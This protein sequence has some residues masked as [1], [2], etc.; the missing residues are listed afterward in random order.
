M[1]KISNKEVYPEDYNVTLE[2]YLIGT[3]SANKKVL[4]TKTF[5]VKSLTEVIKKEVE[6]DF[7]VPKKTSD[8]INDGENGVDKFATAKDIAGKTYQF[9]NLSEVVIPHNLGRYVEPTVIIG[10]EKILTTIH[11]EEDL[12]IIIVKFGKPQT[13]IVLIK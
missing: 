7:E 3:D 1:A 6:I 10:T 5:S 9:S 11:Y 4:Q 13:G 2:D 12:N 8:L